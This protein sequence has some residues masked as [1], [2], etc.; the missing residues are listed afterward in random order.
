MIWY[1]EELTCPEQPEEATLTITG[2]YNPPG[3]RQSMII[4]RLSIE[5]KPGDTLILK[6]LMEK[7]PSYLRIEEPSPDD[8]QAR[9]YRQVLLSR[10]KILK[11]PFSKILEW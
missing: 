3:S 6:T 9:Y 8:I 11:T 4:L 5:P 7:N 10:D 2:I 1:T